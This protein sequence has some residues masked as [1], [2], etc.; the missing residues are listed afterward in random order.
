MT[1]GDEAYTQ[2]EERKSARQALIEALEALDNGNTVSA[3]YHAATAVAL[4][5]AA[6]EPVKEQPV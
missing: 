5:D 1:G 6:S 4:L 3:W 2:A